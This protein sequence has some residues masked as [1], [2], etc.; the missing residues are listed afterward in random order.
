MLVKKPA[1]C[2]EHGEDKASNE[3]LVHEPE[4][5]KSALP[6]APPPQK[7]VLIWPL[8]SQVHH[9]KWWLTNFFA[10]HV[11]IFYMYGE[12]GNDIRTEMQL[13]FQ[14]SPNPS[15]FVTIPKVE[16]TGL[17]LTAAN[18]AVITKKLWVLN[19]QRQAFTRVVQLGQTE[20]HKHGY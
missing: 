3:A 20:F 2:P 10:D 16:M 18:H 4:T 17:T 8:S 13:K 6:P 14:H 5:N 12:M 15:V 1:E 19:E 7:A 11:D 9:L